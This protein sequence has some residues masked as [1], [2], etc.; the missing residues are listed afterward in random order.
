MGGKEIHK[1]QQNA[2]GVRECVSM[3]V[4]MYDYHIGVSIKTSAYMYVYPSPQA[5]A[6]LQV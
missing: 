6:H 5:L 2:I 4:C 3:H 1:K